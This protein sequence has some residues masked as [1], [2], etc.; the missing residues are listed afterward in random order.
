MGG[1]YYRGFRVYLS[2]S[3]GNT[4]PT[5]TAFPGTGMGAGS[6][7]SAYLWAQASAPITGSIDVAYGQYCDSV[8]INLT[9][10][11]DAISSKLGRLPGMGAPLKVN[12]WGG[13]SY[14]YRYRIT[15]DPMSNP[16]RGLS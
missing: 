15:F 3:Y 8:T 5:V 13:P 4:V 10:D 11:D 14:G 2:A 6:A 7:A 16:G 12:V 9:D 1:W